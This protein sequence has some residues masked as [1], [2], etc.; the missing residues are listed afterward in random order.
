M[1]VHVPIAL[2]APQTKQVQPLRRHHGTHCATNPKDQLLKLEV[3]LEREVAHDLL[4]VFDWCYEHVPLQGREAIEED[5]VSVVAIHD[6]MWRLVRLN[7]STDEARPRT[8]DFTDVRFD[9]ERGPRPAHSSETAITGENAGKDGERASVDRGGDRGFAASAPRR[10][11]PRVPVAQKLESHVSEKAPWIG[12]SIWQPLGTSSNCP[13]GPV[14][15]G[16]L[17]K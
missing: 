9:I 3:L 17:R 11:S 16:Q 4:A 15:P 12:E 2:L 1:P 6:F 13:E 7:D 5:D 10:L 14:C 8:G